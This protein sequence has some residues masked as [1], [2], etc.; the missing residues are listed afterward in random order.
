MAEMPEMTWSV[1]KYYYRVAAG[2]RL[3]RP[4]GR[5][6]LASLRGKALFKAYVATWYSQDEDLHCCLAHISRLKEK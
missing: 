4:L 5:A 2:R 3:L 6:R 1:R